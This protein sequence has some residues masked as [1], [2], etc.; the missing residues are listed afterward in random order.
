MQ[1]RRD[2]W[3][4]LRGITM[5]KVKIFADKNLA[6]GKIQPTLYG[7]FI[8]H[9]GRAVYEGIYE[10]GHPTADEDG[11]RGDVIGLIKELNVP[12]VRYPGGNFLSGYDWRDGV[13]PRDKRPTRLDLAWFSTETNE[14]GTDEFMK[15]CKKTGI[16]PMMAVNMGTGTVKDAAQLVEYCNHAGGTAISDARRANGAEEPYNVR[17][18]CIGNEMDGPWQIGHLSADDYGKKALEAAKVM[19]WTNGEFK[20]ENGRT[21]GMQPLKLIVSGSSNHEMKTFPEWDRVVLE[22][23]YPQVDYLSMH[24]YYMYDREDRDPLEDFL[25]SADDMNEYIGTLRATI[26]YVRAKVRSAKR[27]HISF[28]EWNI[29]TVNAP[30]SE[31][32]WKKAPHLL[33]DVYTFQDALVFA[34]LMNTLLNNCDVVHIGCLAQLVNVIAPIMTEKGGGVFRQTSFYPFRYLANYATGETMRTFSDPDLF[35]TKYG[36]AREI[37]ESVTHD[38]ARRSVCVSVCNYAQE[39]REAEIELRSFGDLRAVEYVEM[40]DPDLFAVN[41]FGKEK[42]V[43][44]EKALPDVKDGSRVILRLPA[45]SWSFLRFTY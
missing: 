37:N 35:G 19:R 32:L 1:H 27:V 17:Y 8:E 26:E 41:G 2:L 40:T 14:F 34:G 9:L 5:K 44:H 21:W 16:T 24:R 25:G 3:F 15:W 43:P 6:I 4:G 23:T 36:S 38:G 22:H 42:V 18:W 11:F 39:D 30:R 12:I 7:S 31:P 29:W 45:M 33:E 10:P 28:D 13:G 20:E